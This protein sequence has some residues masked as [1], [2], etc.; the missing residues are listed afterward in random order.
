[1]AYLA[2]PPTSNR[3]NEPIEKNHISPTTEKPSEKS[4]VEQPQSPQVKEA[5]TNAS[6]HHRKEAPW[7]LG[8]W[9]DNELSLF[10]AE[11]IAAIHEVQF[12]LERVKDK[13]TISTAGIKEWTEHFT[14]GKMTTTIWPLTNREAWWIAK[15]YKMNYILLEPERLY[16]L[17]NKRG[18]QPPR[19]PTHQ[20]L[21][22]LFA[23][24]GVPLRRAL[25]EN[26]SKLWETAKA[27]ADY[28]R[29]CELAGIDFD[30]SRL[31]EA[32]RTGSI[33]K[34]KYDLFYEYLSK[35]EHSNN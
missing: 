32:L 22:E 34:T 16:F 21:D 28:E 2:L 13:P 30:T 31:D 33:G 26:P 27:Y 3:E 17:I 8:G 35:S 5:E 29:L 10:S 18:K 14:N 19:N 25:I 6:E 20:K 4:V 9:E 12:W 24:E 15:L 1:M 23:K 11:A 7:Q